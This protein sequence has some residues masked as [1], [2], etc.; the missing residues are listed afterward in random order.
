MKIINTDKLINPTIVLHSKFGYDIK[1]LNKFN[2]Y[3]KEKT[4]NYN[5]I[6]LKML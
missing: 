3:I 4:T 5:I 1:L 6:N 2:F